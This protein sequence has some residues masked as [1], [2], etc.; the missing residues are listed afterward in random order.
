MYATA[1]LIVVL[2][3]QWATLENGPVKA[4]IHDNSEKISTKNPPQYLER[5][6]SAISIQ[7]F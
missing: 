5:E 3:R 6:N 2:D 4:G 1:T 7:M